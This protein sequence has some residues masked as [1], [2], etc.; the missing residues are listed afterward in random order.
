MIRVHTRYKHW[1]KRSLRTL[2]YNGSDHHR[3]VTIYYLGIST[4]E[5][6]FRVYSK[7]ANASPFLNKMVQLLQL[8]YL[9]SSDC[10][11]E[12]LYS[13]KGVIVVLNKF[14]K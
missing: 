4:G 13:A 6:D 1:V 14:V 8:F 10:V 12:E 3:M 9:V 7:R 2:E 5:F 11:V